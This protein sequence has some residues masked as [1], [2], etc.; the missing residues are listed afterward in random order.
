MLVSGHVTSKTTMADSKNPDISQNN[1]QSNENPTS[2]Q[3]E[4][5]QTSKAQAKGTK[6]KALTGNRANTRASTNLETQKPDKRKLEMEHKQI[7]ANVNAILGADQDLSKLPK[8]P[9]LSGK[10]VPAQAA[11]S[12]SQVATDTGGNPSTQ[13]APVNYPYKSPSAPVQGTAPQY[14]DPVPPYLQDITNFQGS[15]QPGVPQ[16]Q[17]NVSFNHPPS[18]PQVFQ[19][20]MVPQQNFTAQPSPVQYPQMVSPQVYMPYQFQPP[21]MLNTPPNNIMYVPSPMYQN[22]QPVNNMNNQAFQAQQQPVQAQQ[23]NVQDPNFQVQNLPQ[24]DFND[25]RADDYAMDNQNY[26]PDQDPGQDIGELDLGFD[27]DQDIAELLAEDGEN[28]DPAVQPDQDIAQPPAQNQMLQGVQ[29]GAPDDQDAFMD[30]EVDSDEEEVGDP[31]SNVKLSVT[32]DHIWEQALKKPEALKIKDIYASIRRPAN[33]NNLTKTLVNPLVKDSTAKEAFKNDIMPRSVQTALI[34]GSL[35][36]VETLQATSDLSVADAVDV[37]E[38]QKSLVTQ[39]RRILQ[40][41]FKSVKCLAYSNIKLN[42]LRRKMQK[43]YLAKKYHR[44]CSKQMDPSH[45]WLY[46]NDVANEIRLQDE[47]N[48]VGRNL[49][50]GGNRNYIWSGPRGFPRGQP[51]WRNPGVQQFRQPYYPPRFQGKTYNFL[52]VL[53][54][55]NVGVS[56]WI[57]DDYHVNSQNLKMVQNPALVN[58][59]VDYNVPTNQTFQLPFYHSINFC[60]SGQRTQTPG[61]QRS[62]VQQGTWPWKPRQLDHATI[63][64]N[65]SIS[66]VSQDYINSQGMVFTTF[67][68]G[69]LEKKIKNWRKLTSDPVILDLV[70]GIK[71][72]FKEPPVQDKLPHE[73]KFS[74]EET[75]LVQQELDRF[76]QMGILS[77]SDIE[78]GDFVSNLFIRKKKDPGKIRILANLKKLNSYVRHIHF[79]MDTLESVLN[80]VRP[81]CY[82]V[83]LD[84]ESSFYA[85]NVHPDHR[86]Y[87]KVIC[88]GKTWVFNKLP[89]GYA[90]SP[91]IFTKLMKIPL[92]YLR[93]EFGYTNAAFIDDLFLLEDTFDFAQQNAFDTVDTVQDLGYTVNVPKSGIKPQQKKNHLGMIIDSIQMIVTLTQE[94]IDKLI[95]H[96]QNILAKNSVQIRSLASLV[97]QMNAARFAVKFGPLHTKSLEIAKNMALVKNQGDFDGFMELS[98]LDKMDIKWWINI[99]PNAYKSLIP[100]PV[101]CTIYTDASLSG[102]G[103]HLQGTQLKG[104]GRWSPQEATLH[105][106]VLE[107]KAIKLAILSLFPDRKNFHVKVF[108]DSMVAIQCINKEGSTQSLPCN[109]ATRSLLLYCE[110][111]KIHISVAHVPGV[112]NQVA[113]QKSRVF[114]NPDT[115]WQI[116]QENFGKICQVLDFHPQIDMF[117]ERLNAKSKVYCSWELDPFA[118][119]I[120]AFTVDWSLYDYIYAFPSFSLVGRVMQKF[121]QTKPAKTQL[122]LLFPVWQTQSWWTTVINHMVQQPV[123]ILTNKQTLTLAHQPEKVHPMANKLVIMGAVLS[124]DIIAHRAFLERF[125]KHSHNHVH[126]PHITNTKYTFKNG[127]HIVIRGRLI[128]SIPI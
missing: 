87:L 58:C 1:G 4:T 110:E 122:L 12:S 108:S 22:P 43:P 57:I 44:L 73:I 107:I 30:D 75:I 76:V 81:G 113:D 39:R 86:K 2:K 20:N 59:V 29:V 106:N 11:G 105:V 21:Q 69:G 99:C 125:P 103:F 60:S 80:M 91:Y 78:P 47:A 34:K 89:M 15:A 94:K 93:T 62:G 126:T 3:S 92:T 19:Q 120:D 95:D 5:K 49:G 104:G 37:T 7:M 9:K 41:G 98:V 32:I 121:L 109:A 23:Q 54:T 26:W 45:Q 52:P 72:D 55:N 124:T 33:V 118:Q 61:H 6:G 40:K 90:Q 63:Q 10:P 65:R 17:P 112:E 50:R 68:Q 71:L 82:M 46:G 42:Q 51:R 24:P 14:M 27:P 102:Y 70:Q 96:A 117:A 127:M 128:P 8:I 77:E 119:H 38:A 56:K 64:L 101:D 79:K 36:V 67:K 114:K 16:N 48:K 66:P 115:E 35:A 83:S 116:S 18:M 31:L 84:L 28:Q 123:T 100:P 97:G 25:E 111:N 13:I 88:M 74:P 53:A 85:L